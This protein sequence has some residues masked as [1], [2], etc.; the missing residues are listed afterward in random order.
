MTYK[1]SNLCEDKGKVHPRQRE[2]LEKDLNV[3]TSLVFEKR[4]K[5]HV[6]G[7]ISVWESGTR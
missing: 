2:Q 5:T 6:V 1:K 3:G 4:R 7:A